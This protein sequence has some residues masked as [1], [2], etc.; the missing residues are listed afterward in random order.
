MEREREALCQTPSDSREALCHM[1]REREACANNHRGAGGETRLPRP[2]VQH[3][4]SCQTHYI[5]A[6]DGGT[7]PLAA[8]L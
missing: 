7:P 6:D 5:D 3:V 4:T 8:S 2:L 1:E